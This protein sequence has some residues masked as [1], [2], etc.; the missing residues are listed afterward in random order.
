MEMLSG[1]TT[2]MLQR[3]A[4]KTQSKCAPDESVYREFNQVQEDLF[5]SNMTR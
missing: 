4:M 2:A 5:G 3:K 1:T